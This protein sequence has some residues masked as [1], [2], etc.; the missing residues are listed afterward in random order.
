MGLM[1]KSVLS[2]DN[3]DLKKYDLFVDLDQLESR[4]SG[5]L[6]HGIERTLK[7]I[8]IMSQMKIANAFARIRVLASQDK[9]SGKDLYDAYFDI[10]SMIVEPFSKDDLDKMSQWQCGA[11][12]QQIEDHITGRMRIKDSEKKKT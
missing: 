1:E 9:I 4:T 8:S 10:F 2:S 11:L 7:P 3:V 6:L 12:Y 5:L